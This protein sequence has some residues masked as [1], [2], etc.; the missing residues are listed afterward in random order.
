MRG[1]SL[2]T[3]PVEKWRTIIEYAKKYK[4]DTMIETGTYLGDTIWAVRKHFKRIYSIE[5]DEKLATMARRR[6]S[7]YSYIFIYHGD[8][9]SVL[10]QLLNNILFPCIFWLDA[11]Y[12]G[13]ITTKGIEESPIIKELLSISRHRIKEH[14]ILIDDALSFDG[15]N[16]YPDIEELKLFVATNYKGYIFEVRDSIIRIHK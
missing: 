10:S 12:S 4:I 9:S 8:S 5:L 1:D 2:T 11:H 15:Q 7:N 16:G 3:P 13:G 14:V 6:F